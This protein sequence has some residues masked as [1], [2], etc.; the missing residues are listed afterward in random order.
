[1]KKLL[2]GLAFVTSIPSFAGTGFVE[3]SSLELKEK[4]VCEL[5]ALKKA[6]SFAMNNKAQDFDVYGFR[7]VDND[8]RHLSPS[9]YSWYELD[10][11]VNEGPKTIRTLVQKNR[12]N[13]DCI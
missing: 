11:E 13:G 8:K 3:Q 4:G 12:L 5:V 1:M 10:I 2:L 7:L 6:I 9:H